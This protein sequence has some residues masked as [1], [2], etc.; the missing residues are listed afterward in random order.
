LAGAIIWASPPEELPFYSETY[1]PFWAAAQD[2]QMPLSLHEFAGFQ[3]VD[4]D[5]NSEKRTIAQAINSHEVERTFAT[6]ILSGVLERFPGLKVVAAELNCG[7][8][9]F[10]L[11]RIDERFAATGIRFRG[12]PFPTKLTMKP[13]DYFRRQLYATFIDDLFGIAHR[14]DIGVENIMWS[15]DFP[16]SA[17]FWPHSQ[18]KIEKDFTGVSQEDKHKIL[19]ENTARL[20]GF[21]LD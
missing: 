3:W 7:W 9:P 2:L 13:G 18:E 5:S 15:S 17:T 12:T 4:W 16:H 19:C 8:L 6:L 1:D 10:F 11:F 21:E 14:H 20:Y